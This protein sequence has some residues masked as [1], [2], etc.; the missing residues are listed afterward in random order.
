M[1]ALCCPF[2]TTLLMI[3]HILYVKCVW[4]KGKSDFASEIDIRLE[5]RL[6]LKVDYTIHIKCTHFFFR[7]ILV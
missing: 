7:T 6:P 3:T 5:E 4:L 1:L 2:F